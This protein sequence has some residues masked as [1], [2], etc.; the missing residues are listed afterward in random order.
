MTQNFHDPD[1][2]RQRSDHL[3]REA[4][5]TLRMVAELP[6]PSELTDRVHQRL[7]HA[8][9]SMPRRRFWSFWL[10]AQRLQFAGAAALVVVFVGST[11]SVYYSK[12]SHVKRGAPIGVAAPQGP[13]APASGGFGTA[14]AERHPSTLT[15]IEV[16]P[17]R[18]KKPSASHTAAKRT[19]KVDANQSAASPAG[20]KSSTTPE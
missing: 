16:P 20:F 11:W 2:A 3:D 7:S 12:T 8:R 17:A 4:E 10:P 15:P 13:V 6:P 1:S 19:P 9:A 18:K 14:G 5:Q